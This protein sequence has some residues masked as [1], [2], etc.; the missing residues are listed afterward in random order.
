MDPRTKWSNQPSIKRICNGLEIT[1]RQPAMA[2]LC[3]GSGL[4]TSFSL[5][6]NGNYCLKILPRSTIHTYLYLQPSLSST[7]PR[8]IISYVFVFLKATVSWGISILSKPSEATQPKSTAESSTSVC[9]HRCDTGP[10]PSPLLEPESDQ[11]DTR[12]GRRAGPKPDADSGPPNN[13]FLPFW[14]EISG[15]LEEGTRAFSF[16]KSR[17]LSDLCSLWGRASSAGSNVRAACA[18]R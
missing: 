2:R 11:N 10:P 17:A 14:T 12:Q 9:S 1:T 8:R 3:E 13:A 18:L 7:F 16:S 6:Q 5:P 15:V 4:L